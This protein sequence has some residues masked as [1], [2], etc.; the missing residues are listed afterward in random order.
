MHLEK[1]YIFKIT[2]M[3]LLEALYLIEA[4]QSN[5][6]IF[7]FISQIDILNTLK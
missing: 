2:I 4:S 5:D 1:S 7:K 6:V 3:S